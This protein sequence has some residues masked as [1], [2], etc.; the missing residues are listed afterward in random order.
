[1]VDNL[2]DMPFA[3]SVHQRPLSCM[4]DVM[5]DSEDSDVVEPSEPQTASGSSSNNP[6][7]AESLQ[8]SQPHPP[9]RVGRPSRLKPAAPPPR[10]SPRLAEAT[11]DGGH[12]RE[13][14]ESHN[15]SIIA[16]TDRP[17]RTF[18]RNGA[19]DKPVEDHIAHR[20]KQKPLFAMPKYRSPQ[21]EV[22]LAVDGFNPP[23]SEDSSKSH[24]SPLDHYALPFRLP[25]PCPMPIKSERTNGLDYGLSQPH[26]EAYPPDWPEEMT[27]LVRPR[28]IVMSWDLNNCF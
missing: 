15:G 26:L 11:E 8:P 18:F 4:P 10:V 13:G 22:L 25:Q 28:E 2:R 1:M 7:D 6:Y 12:L 3:P 16:G 5:D 27:S 21:T 23:W 24:A 14:C 9:N 19:F 17:K 20:R